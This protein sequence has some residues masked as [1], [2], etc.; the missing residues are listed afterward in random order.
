MGRMQALANSRR[1]VVVVVVM[2]SGRSVVIIV[3]VHRLVGLIVLL[4]P[5]QVG[6]QVSA[7]VKVCLKDENL[8]LSEEKLCELGNE[9]RLTINTQH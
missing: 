9:N 4:L 2:M 6:V 8:P 3:V 1:R 7:E 5:K